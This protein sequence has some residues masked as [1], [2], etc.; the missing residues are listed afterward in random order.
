M[1]LDAFQQILFIVPHFYI[2]CWE[3]QER[4]YGLIIDIP[5]DINIRINVK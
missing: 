1:T 4:D 3:K 5:S 2:Y